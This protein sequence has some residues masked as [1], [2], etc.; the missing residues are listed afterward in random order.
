MA[1]M[2]VETLTAME[3]AELVWI[4]C[5]AWTHMMKWARQVPTNISKHFELYSLVA[6]CTALT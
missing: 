1:P 6:S 2:R 3:V 5:L 4:L